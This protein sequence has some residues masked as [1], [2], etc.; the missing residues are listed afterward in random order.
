MLRRPLPPSDLHLGYVHCWALL[1]GAAVSTQ[2]LHVVL[3]LKRHI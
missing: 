2:R 3:H 1:T